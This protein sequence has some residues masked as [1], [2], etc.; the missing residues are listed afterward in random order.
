MPAV[1]PDLLDESAV[2][3]ALGAGGK[4]FAKSSLQRLQS[5]D[6]E[7]PRPIMVGRSRRW[8]SAEIAEWFTTRKRRQYCQLGSASR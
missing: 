7:F 2:R 6:P 4:P 3:Q 8:F 1:L 5:L